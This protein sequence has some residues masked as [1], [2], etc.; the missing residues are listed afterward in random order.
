MNTEA[1]M[2]NWIK[3]KFSTFQ[4]NTSQVSIELAR[5]L[6][7]TDLFLSLFCMVNQKKKKKILGTFI[8]FY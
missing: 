6:S 1:A 5:T 8:T 2:V 3:S 7:A 4:M